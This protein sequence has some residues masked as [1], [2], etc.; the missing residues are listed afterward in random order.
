MYNLNGAAKVNAFIE[1]HRLIPKLVA[2]ISR[3][4]EK[5]TNV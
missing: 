5:P 4:Q 3:K 2:M 1:I